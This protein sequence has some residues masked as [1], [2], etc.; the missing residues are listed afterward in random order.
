MSDIDVV[1]VIGHSLGNVDL[2]YF[3][4]VFNSIDENAIW[5]VYYYESS[6]DKIFKKILCDLGIREDNIIMLPTQKIKI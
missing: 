5:N 6:D 4:K 3:I 1:E 2:P